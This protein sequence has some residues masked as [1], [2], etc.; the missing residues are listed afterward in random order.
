LYLYP[1]I[2]IIRADG[3]E[4]NIWIQTYPNPFS[5]TTQVDLSVANSG[6]TTLTLYD[7]LGRKL[8]Q[9]D[10]YLEAGLHHFNLAVSQSGY[11][12]LHITTPQGVATAKLLSQGSK[13]STTPSLVYAG[14][15]PT[16]SAKDRK[17]YDPNFPFT[18]GD[19][20]HYT[21]YV[22][23]KD[24]VYLQGMDTAITETAVF[25]VD[26]LNEDSFIDTIPIQVV[27]SIIEYSY[28]P[29]PCYYDN[30]AWDT[31]V[32]INTQE[33][34]DLLF[35]C[36]NL[37]QPFIDFL[38]QSALVVKGWTGSRNIIIYSHNLMK[39]CL[40]QYIL[41]IDIGEGATLTPSNFFEIIA[42]DYKIAKNEIIYLEK[43]VFFYK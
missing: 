41:K 8:V 22:S 16:N 39:N 42:T 3:I 21:T 17:L 24:S 1:P 37:A 20:F 29:P 9:Q 19:T 30:I 2:G 36:T 6:N 5:N 4:N 31:V 28:P 18:L 38:N 40:N 35:S 13:E 7:L 27:E 25:T 14:I 23:T 10:R 34:M 26:F 33:D 15:T 43:N 12:F 32:L 11:Y